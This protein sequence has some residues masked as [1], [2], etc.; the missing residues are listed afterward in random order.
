MQRLIS[1]AALAF[2][3]ATAAPLSANAAVWAVQDVD[4]TVIRMEGTIFEGDADEFEK[5]LKNGKF[6]PGIRVHL[7]SGGGD[8]TESYKIG[9]LLRQYKAT[10]SHGYCASSC[11]FAYIGGTDRIT[12]T[13]ASGNLKKGLVV[14]KPMATKPFDDSMLPYVEGLLREL[15]DYCDNMTGSDSFHQVMIKTPF[16]TPRALTNTEAR[17]MGVVD[18]IY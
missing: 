13:E 11:V 15:R 7:S 12:S 16:E 9:R 3:A 18:H 10:V 6:K 17:S 5:I 14:H 8:V 1:Q 4:G 2:L